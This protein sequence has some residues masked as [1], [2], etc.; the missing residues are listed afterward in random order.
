MGYC[1]RISSG[2]K[3]N[4]YFIGYKD[5]WW[6]YNKTITHKLSKISIYVKGCD[7]ETKQIHFL[8]EDGELLKKCNGTCNKVSNSI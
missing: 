3:I 4:K 6:V 5:W 8:I 2:D 1:S 7:G